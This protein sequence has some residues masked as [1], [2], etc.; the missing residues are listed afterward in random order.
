[1]DLK[2]LLGEKYT[3]EL[4]TLLES[5]LKNYV[6]NDNGQYVPKERFNE[7]NEQFKNAKNQLKTIEDKNKTAEQ[8]VAEKLAE[9]E[10]LKKQYNVELN[11][12][13]VLKVLSASGMVGAEDIANSIVSDNKEDSLTK[14]KMLA[15]NWATSAQKLKETFEKEH[16]NI[17]PPKPS[18]GKNQAFKKL[19]ATEK[20]FLYSTDKQAYDAY[21]VEEKAYNETQQ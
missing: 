17:E 13:D 21:I 3:E 9:A 12:V 7:V 5:N 11:K 1:M 16:S 2:K 20:G 8:L 14:A 6:L 4:A 18:G 19:N 15:D 10:N